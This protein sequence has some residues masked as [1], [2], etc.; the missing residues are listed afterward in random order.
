MGRLDGAAAPDNDEEVGKLSD[1]K[2]V[3]PLEGDDEEEQI[4]IDHWIVISF[5]Y[6][7]ITSSV[8]LMSGPVPMMHRPAKKA[9]ASLD[10]AL[11]EVSGSRLLAIHDAVAFL[12]QCL[13]AAN[14]GL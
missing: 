7:S 5:L 14:G 10:A 8:P 1:E 3:A 2:L 9:Q 12:V 4:V 11:E 6:A 13:C